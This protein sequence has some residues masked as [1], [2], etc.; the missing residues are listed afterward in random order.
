[1]TGDNRKLV[2]SAIENGTVLDHIPADNIFKVIDI[3]GLSK[4]DNQITI[5]INL[6]SG[7]L[8]RK[9]IIKI[10]G[11]YFEDEEM[12]R[13][14]LV[15]PDATVNIIRDYTVIE[16]KTISIPS[17]VVGIVRCANPLCVTN[18]QDIK[19]KFTTVNA[20]GRTQLLC[21]YCEKATELK[22]AEIKTNKN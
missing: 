7:S 16:K 22:T 10:A 19:T 18:H 14:A 15:A 20:A 8:G 6:E 5:G 4:S 12:S 2:V 21:H 9:G 3:L 13:I 17:E 1:M 11:R